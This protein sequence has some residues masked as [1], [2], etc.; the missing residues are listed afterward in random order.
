MGWPRWTVLAQAW[1]AMAAVGVLQYGYG[2]VAP[3]LMQRNG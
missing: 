2:A 3:V 1:L